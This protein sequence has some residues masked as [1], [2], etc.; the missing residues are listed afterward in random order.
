[1]GGELQIVEI[2]TAYPMG[3][4]VLALYGGTIS[5]SWAY[6]GNVVPGIDYLQLEI[7]DSTGDC[8]TTAE[9]T[10]LVAHSLIG[11]TETTHGVT[12]TYTLSICNVAGCNPTTASASAT[13]D[14]VVD[15]SPGTSG[16]YVMQVMIQNPGLF[17][18][19][20]SATHLMFQGG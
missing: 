4:S 14:S 16:V 11:Q 13:A 1:M 8:I 9:N 5:A 17:L 15:G 20:F 3:L 2:T 12:Y 7:C 18:G 10:T 6:V 19:I